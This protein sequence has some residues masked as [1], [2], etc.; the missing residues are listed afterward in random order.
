MIMHGMFVCKFNLTIIAADGE[1]NMNGVYIKY[2]HAII[3][4]QQE[5]DTVS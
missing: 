4:L 3:L 1:Q 2:V 5:H